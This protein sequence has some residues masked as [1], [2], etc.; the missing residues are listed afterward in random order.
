MRVPVPALLSMLVL[1]GCALPPIV[2]VASL[3]A[4]G[5][6]Y[7]TTGKGTTDHAISAV[8]GED[9]AILRAAKD[10]EICDPDGEV[11]VKLDGA[12]TTD[13]DWYYD[14]ETGSPSAPPPAPVQSP[15]E[16]LAAVDPV[17]AAPAQPAITNKPSATGAPATSKRAT[18]L[19]R[20]IDLA[21]EPTT[22][23]L[24]ADARPAPKPAAPIVQQ[25]QARRP[26]QRQ[27]EPEAEQPQSWF[28]KLTG[29]SR[30]VSDESTR[31]A[32]SAAP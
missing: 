3:A 14:P 28:E 7:A 6:S 2:T 8:A 19:D 12:T 20:L 22:R 25:A 11:L 13:A 32:A 23:G 5:V 18:S 24:F 16:L 26:V 10:E 4:N 31:E 21:A 29:K 9:C 15:N 27:P 1:S 30:G 17:S